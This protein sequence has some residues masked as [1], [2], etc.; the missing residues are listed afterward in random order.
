MILID[1]LLCMLLQQTQTV[2]QLNYLVKIFLQNPSILQYIPK[3]LLSSNAQHNSR[4]SDHSEVQLKA[5]VVDENQGL[6]GD[7][8]SKFCIEE[9]RC[10]T[11]VLTK[12]DDF[13]AVRR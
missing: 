5:I 10:V 7:N 4:L 3:E 2:S 9:N 6:I 1:L 13:C 8:F 11:C 12:N